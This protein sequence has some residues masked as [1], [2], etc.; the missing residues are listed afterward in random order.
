MPPTAGTLELFNGLGGFADGRPEYVITVD[1]DAGAY[2]PAPWSNVV[3]NPTFGFAA[4]DRGRGYTWSEN[5]H[6]NRLTPWRN[7]PVCDPPG[8]AMFLRDDETG[9]FWSATPLPAGRRPAYTVRHGQGYTT[10]EHARDGIASTLRL[11]VPRD[12]PVKIFRLALR[13]DLGARAPAVGDAVRRLGA[14]REPR[15]HAPARRHEPRAGDRRAARAQR[16]PRRSSA[17]AWRSSI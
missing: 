14:R 6:D 8:E 3:A 13:N 7:D 11:F 16:L 12:E 4:T 5:S 17:S 1:P 10:Y 9:A 2:R 15:A